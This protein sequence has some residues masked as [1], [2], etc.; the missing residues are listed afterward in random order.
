MSIADLKEWASLVSNMNVLVRKIND[1]YDWEHQRMSHSGQEY[2][3]DIHNDIIPQMGK[4]M[5]TLYFRFDMDYAKRKKEF[6][7]EIKLKEYKNYPRINDDSKNE[8]EKNL[9]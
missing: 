1:L 7:H 3:E 2:I 8:I 4:D 9:P 5:K 6:L